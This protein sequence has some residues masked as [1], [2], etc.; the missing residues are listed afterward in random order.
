M[1]SEEE[2]LNLVHE[3]TCSN[4]DIRLVVMNGSRVNPNAKKDP[5]QDYDIACFV[6]NMEPF[7]RNLNIS[8]FFGELMILQLPEDMVD[9]PPKDEGWYSYLMQFTDGT[10]I[11]LG[12]H[13]LDELQQCLDDSLT[14]VLLDKDN[15]IG[16]L[17]PP[18]EL[19]YLTR[20]P[21]AKQFDDCCNEFWWL[22]PYVAKGLWRDELTYARY[23]LDVHMRGEMMKMLVWYFGVQTGFQKSPGKLGKHL[24]GQID[25]ELWALLEHTFADANLEHCWEALFA[26]GDLFRRVA[27]PV[28]R[29]F[30][31]I[32]PEGDDQRVS[33]YIR[34]IK[35]LPRDALI[36]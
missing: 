8:A 4:D 36:I 34:R 19:G 30:G 23:M 22:N 2:I 20:P 10:R 11:D 14:V 33:E 25:D 12:F 18:S 6:R 13:P 17:P 27:Q 9:P 29:K 5:F 3:F 21:T 28:A 7:R 31:F 16:E 24:K 1:R 32:Y 35:E 26:M 15:L